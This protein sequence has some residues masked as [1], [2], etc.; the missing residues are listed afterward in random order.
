MEKVNLTEMFASFDEQWAPCL[1]GELNGQAVKLAKVESEFVWHH[2]DD[3]DELFLV[4]SGELRIEFHDESDVV[5]RE[6]EFVIVRRG[7][8]T[9]LSR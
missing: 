1:A 8:G 5:L 2:F 9:P 7:V 3:A 4:T 6:W